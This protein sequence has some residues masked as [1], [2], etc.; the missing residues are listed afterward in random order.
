MCKQAL[1]YFITDWQDYFEHTKNILDK[2]SFFSILKDNM[3][4]DI[5]KNRPQTHFE[6]R[7]KK[8]KLPIMEIIYTKI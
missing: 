6:K 4:T 2:N 7:A 5:K 1:L 3:L 8:I